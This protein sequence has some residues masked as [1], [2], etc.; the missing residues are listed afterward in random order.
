MSQNVSRGRR[1]TCLASNRNPRRY[2]ADTAFIY[3]CENPGHALRAMGLDVSWGHIRGWRRHAA[4]CVVVHRPRVS[5]RLWQLLRG[6]R[7]A[8]ARLVAD[9]DD[10]VF[11]ESLARFSPA[12]INRSAPLRH[13]RRWFRERHAAVDWFDQ[14]T[15]STDELRRHAERCFPGKHPEVQLRVTGP[16]DFDLAVPPQ[17]ILR[18][19]KVP[20]AAF[21]GQ[22]AGIWVNLVPY[23]VQY[24]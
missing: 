7:R 13:L 16:V 18:R 11:D 10:L 23:P 14:I 24:R 17:Q 22:F 6:L 15:V 19:D 5:F 1:L 3:R 2:L 4:D 21:A 9:F 8:G 20:F 12:V